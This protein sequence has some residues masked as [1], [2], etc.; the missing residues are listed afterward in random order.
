MRSLL[1]ATRSDV[2]RLGSV[3]PTK[4]FA[5]AGCV[6]AGPSASVAAGVG[7]AAVGAAVTMGAR[8]VRGA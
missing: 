4:T 2:V 8:M 6:A 1:N 7:P 5:M 3:V